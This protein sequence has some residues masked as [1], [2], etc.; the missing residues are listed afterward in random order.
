[1]TRQMVMVGFLQAQNC[2]TLA[3]AWRHPEAR[4]DFTTAAYYQ[5]IGQVLEEGTP[6]R[7]FGDARM[8]RTRAFLQ[9]V[10]HAPAAAMPAPPASDARS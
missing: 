3:S 5:R 2:T 4:S 9:R 1:M 10:E 6:D 7:I 8:A